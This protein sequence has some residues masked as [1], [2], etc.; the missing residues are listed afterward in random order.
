MEVLTKIIQLLLSLSMLV[1]VHELGHYF[2]A[3]IFKTRVEKFYL[4]FNPWFSIFKFKRGDTTY[5]LGWLPLGGYVKISGMIDESM[6]KEAMKKEPKPWEFRS[7]P[8][9]QRLLIMIGGVAMNVVFAIVIFTFILFVW[10][11]QYLPTSS[12]KYGISVNEYGRKLGLQDGDKI[13]KIDGKEIENFAKIPFEILLDKTQTITVERD[14]QVIDLPVDKNTVNK[15]IR[16]KQFRFIAPLFP[17]LVAG[18]AENSAAI[19]AGVKLGDIIISVNDTPTPFFS[20]LRD[21]LVANKNKEVTM[22]VLRETDTVNL[23]VVVPE[24]GLLGINISQ[25][26]SLHFDLKTIEYNLFQSIPAGF[27]LAY[28]T[29]A[30]YLKQ[31]RVIF[32][33]ETKAYESVGGFISIGNLFPATWDWYQFWRM[34]AFLSIILAIM[35]LL[36]IP[37]LDGG[38]VMFLMWEIITRR[39][40]NEKFI[41]YAQVAGMLF[42]LL[43]VLWANGNDILRLFQ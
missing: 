28:T 11:E 16:E 1:L 38:H 13:L 14:N 12:V 5:G 10:G 40:P 42:L 8:S 19:N 30:D 35:N 20:A 3:R 4:F 27:R 2:A 9:W 43:L 25:D 29:S 15:I 39:K 36:P 17:N 6:D 34:T 24:S 7:K 23:S 31:L 22:K 21:V 37:A 32:T 18:M 41:E 33:P 26:P